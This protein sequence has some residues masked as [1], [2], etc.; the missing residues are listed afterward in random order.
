MEIRRQRD[1]LRKSL[2]WSFGP[3]LL[4]IGTFVLALAMV[5]RRDRGIF[6]NGLPFLILVVAW[7]VA[8]LIIGL[9]QQRT[10]QRELDE[11]SE[12][13]RENPGA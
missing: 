11:L 5:G 8:Y 12:I 3:I 4:A 9:H 7:I 6:P 10:L 1:V 13:A 2:V